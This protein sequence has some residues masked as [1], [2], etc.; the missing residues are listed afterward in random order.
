MS[1]TPTVLVYG[2][3]GTQG[4]PVA[5]HLLARG[6]RVRAVTR[7]RAQA[8]ALAVAG[9]EIAV[10][11]QDDPDALR[12]VSEGVD[13]AFVMASASVLAPVY[14]RHMGHAL[15]AARDAGVPHVVL[16]MSGMIPDEES[17]APAL[18]AKA[19]VV[20]A[21]QDLAPRATVLT[22][23]LYLENLL[24]VAEALRTGVLPYP[25]AAD[26]PI[27]WQS[28]DDHGAAAAAALLDPPPAGTRIDLGGPEAVT[29][30]ELASRI[31]AAIGR[32][33]SFV[34]ITPAD[35]A[36]QVEP[37]I[38]AA[39]ARQVAASYAYEAAGG[40]KALAPDP[41]SAAGLAFEPTPLDAW[42]TRVLAPALR[43]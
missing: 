7:D 23:T 2:A 21:A 32:D 5:R 10:A 20:V 11:D 15:A 28:L 40:A 34:P 18:D 39:V 41:G 37:F 36:R 35:F 16:G 33:V 4:G 26:V 8:S 17:G 29:G 22:T 38:G 3:T 43:G 14:E 30:P 27:A 13:A 24:L 42:I 9:A 19:R 25:I 6:A 31:G 12:R 1:S